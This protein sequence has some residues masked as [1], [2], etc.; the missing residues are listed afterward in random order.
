ME[1]KNET[2]LIQ[3]NR[4][5]NFFKK[6][7][8]NDTKIL[9]RAFK[10]AFQA[11]KNCYRK[12]GDPYICHPL[13]VSEICT[14]EMGL[15]F[16]SGICAILHDC[17]E[18][19]NISLENIKSVFGEEKS[20]IIDGLTKIKN[21]I[22]NPQKSNCIDNFRKLML[23]LVK[24]LR[25]ILIKI[26]DRLH[27]MRTLQY[28]PREKQLI[29]SYETLHIYAPIACRMGLYNIKSELEDLSMQYINRNEYNYV[30]FKLKKIQRECYS[31]I[32]EFIYPIKKSL[33]EQNIECKI[34][35]RTKSIFSIWNKM[36]NKNI[37]FSNLYDLFAVRIIINNS[38]HPKTD[39]WRVYSIITDHYF[40][41]QNRLRD[42]ISNPKSNGYQSLHTTV[43][44]Y[45]K[46]IEV[47][48]RTKNMNEIAERGIA[49]HWKYKE[50]NKDSTID[51]WIHKVRD[52]IKKP[53]KNENLI[54][55]FKMNLFEDEIFVYTP[56]G[57]LIKLPKRSI[58]IDFAFEIHTDIGMHCIGAKINNKIES[59]KYVLQNGDHVEII[60]SK[61]QNPNKDWLNFVITSKAKDKIR[62]FL[63]I[64]RNKNIQIGK[65][66]LHYQ[67]NKINININQNNLYMIMK[68]YNI[69]SIN[70]LYCKFINKKYNIN[71]DIKQYVQQHNIK[72]NILKYNK[73]DI[74]KRN[75]YSKS[76]ILTKN[77]FNFLNYELS[78][79]CNPIQGNYIFGFIT[80]D[81]RIK[82]HKTNCLNSVRLFNKYFY[83]VINIKWKSDKNIKFN[84][85]LQ[86]ELLNKNDLF[87]EISKYISINLKIV[88]NTKF[89]SYNKDGKINS[90][91]S[92]NVNNDKS[93]NE[94]EK[95]IKL[96]NGIYY[97]NRIC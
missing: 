2:I 41:N 52:L 76:L 60:T 31:L 84:L 48:I 95:K 28:M 87:Y 56:K 70:D 55:E 86:N 25:V 1:V 43:K 39:C 33:K 85:K 46:W 89:A 16:T 66:N 8:N 75:Q 74:N 34:I 93:S 14:F 67:M 23:S 62:N 9:E 59:L 38:K 49:A 51:K 13:S 6:D 65:N 36:K 47:Q 17:I 32:K 26:A 97:V 90:I 83:R 91:I 4:I 11:H 78:R 27:N 57:E 61:K 94:I 53:I 80:S 58:V 35:E 71:S 30:S 88:V 29:I 69:L 42:W 12:S 82:I 72:N 5:F 44:G 96:I 40:P 18:D 79:C 92:L 22:K 21:I 37:S 10:M 20:N 81:H 63:L 19:T 77:G 73:Y 15:D 50:N 45:N 64:S 68:Y 7:K 24:D 54:D 3:Y